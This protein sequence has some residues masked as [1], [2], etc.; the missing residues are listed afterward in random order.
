M[1]DQNLD[2]LIKSLKTEAIDAAEKEAA[3]ILHEATLKAQA[4]LD[5]AKKKKSQIIADAETEAEAIV[6]KG[7]AAIQ[8]AG[9][10]LTL[11]LQDD[12]LQ[13]FRSALEIEITKEFTP[14]L[15]KSV[16]ISMIENV[17]SGVEIKLPIET[18]RELGDFISSQ[19]K[20]TGDNI[21]FG[22]D[23]SLV[24]G[25]KIKETGEGWYYHIT[26]ETIAEALQ[27]CLTDYWISIL[28]EKK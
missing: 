27:P 26:P 22:Q 1:S 10:D 12:L 28:K 23:D 2:Q 17:G 4:S 9:R 8:Q 16:I 18:I 14:E 19:I 20:S 6:R 13:L 3:K 15:V 25:M 24:S 7:E 21:L 11:S 5:K